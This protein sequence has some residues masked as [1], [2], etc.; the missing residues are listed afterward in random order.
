V[1][2][3]DHRN[4]IGEL[5]HRFSTF[6]SIEEIDESLNLLL[7]PLENNLNETLSRIRSVIKQ[8]LG[9]RIAENYYIKGS[10][11]EPY[12]IEIEPSLIEFNV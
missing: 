12:R 11:G 5:Y 10:R 4:E 7:D 6:S 1:E 8:T 2:L 9:Q 3:V